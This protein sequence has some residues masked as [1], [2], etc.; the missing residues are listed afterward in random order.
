[1]GLRNRN[2]SAKAAPGTVFETKEVRPAPECARAALCRTASLSLLVAKEAAVRLTQI[3]LLVCYSDFLPS[4]LQNLPTDKYS[5][6]LLLCSIQFLLR[7]AII[8]SFIGRLYF[9]PGNNSKK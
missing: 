5:S 9:F 2:S 7:N 1:M 3:N 6:L 8:S 4:K